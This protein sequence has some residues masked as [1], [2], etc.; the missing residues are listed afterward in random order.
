MRWDGL[1]ADLEAQADAYE[2]AERAAEVEE[3][4]RVELG[5]QQ[6]TGR[7]RAA[8]GTDIG[9]RCAGGVTVTGRLDRVGSDWLLIDEGGGRECLAVLAAVLSVRG[10]NRFARVDDRGVVESRL[11]LRHALRGVARDRSAVRLHLTDGSTLAGTLDRVGADFVEAA[12]H[13]LGEARRASDV[14]GV[15]LVT[16]GSLV[17]VRRDA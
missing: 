7:L 15:H 8:V 17:A 11:G 5:A 4:A 2:R 13:P 10:V 1:F 3:R 6:L 12:T 16:I 9:L 14:L